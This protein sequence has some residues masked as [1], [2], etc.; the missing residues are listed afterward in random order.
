[1][2]PNL[3]LVK[4]DDVEN[5]WFGARPLI[6]K[7]LDHAEGALTTTDALRL[8]LNGRMNLWVGFDDNHRIFVAVLTEI[9]SYPRHKICRVITTATATGHDFDEWF[10]TMYGIIEKF[11][12]SKGCSA[13]EAWVRK[14]LARKL[15]WDHE[16]SVI[17]KVLKYKPEVLDE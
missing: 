14:G 17:Y 9:I 5:I 13:F 16:Y 10:P 6:Q 8:V 12:L 1:M 15:K 2:T 11:A 3:F 4:P 7:A